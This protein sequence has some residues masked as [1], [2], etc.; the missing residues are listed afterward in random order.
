MSLIT[1]ERVAA[2]AASWNPSVNPDFEGYWQGRKWYQPKDLSD[3]GS[4]YIYSKGEVRKRYLQ[5]T[6]LPD[7][8]LTDLLAFVADMEGG[9]YKF[10]FTDVDSVDY[11]ASRILNA[12]NVIYREV[13][14]G[15]HEV[16]LELEVA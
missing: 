9:R 1:F 11:M 13:A 16:Y 2:P 14:S 4:P 3:G 8:D 6:M 7:A 10:T 15:Y 12:G 5:W